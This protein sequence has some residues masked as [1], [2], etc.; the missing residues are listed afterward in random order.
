MLRTVRSLAPSVAWT[1]TGTVFNQGS[2]LVS[3]IWIANE[4]GKSLFGEYAIV[5]A[6]VQATVA[7]AGLGIGYTTTRYVAEW[8]HRDAVRAGKLLGLFSRLSWF[9]A[10]ISALLLAAWAST[11]A[12]GALAAPSVGQP[13]LIAATATLFNARNGFLTG[14]LQ[15]LEAFRFIGIGGVIS[16]IGY[17][18]LTAAGAKIDGVRGAA[19]GLLASS[20]LQCAVLT[21]AMHRE[22]RKQRLGRESASL[23]A[24]LSL[25]LRFCLPGALSPISTVP[26]LWAVQA[27][28]VRSPNRFAELAVY[29]VGLNLLTVVMFPPNMLGG[30]AMVHINRALVVDGEAGYRSAVRLNVAVTLALVMVSLPVV[31]LLGPTLL[32][33][34]GKDFRSGYAAIGL[35]LLA[36]IPES[37]TIALSQSLQTRERMWEALLGV[38]FPRDI[39]MIVVAWKFV[40]LYGAFGAAAAYLAG[41]TMGLITTCVMLRHEL[42]SARPTGTPVSA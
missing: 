15:G 31:A 37:L 24:E 2:T 8:R 1:T 14:A 25:I 6:T 27:F 12:N 26:V 19:V 5:L 32:D 28:L 34:Y 33:L 9:A 3:N 30:V 16:G 18:L 13:L 23:K 42:R 11:I 21:L 38:N 10:I 4:L 20:M 39:T 35:L 7:M 41:R 36:A 29:A 22:R 17:L 40:P